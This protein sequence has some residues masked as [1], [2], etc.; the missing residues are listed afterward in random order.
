MSVELR[1][2]IDVDKGT[3]VGRLAVGW[4]V[5]AFAGDDRGDLAAF[6]ALARLVAEG[7]LADAVGIG[8][9]SPEAPTELPAVT[10]VTVAG[11]VG[12]VGLLSE[13]AA[14]A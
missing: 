4:R 14:R 1:P 12:L 5:A 7:A 2:A 6:A 9:L 13:L 3:V 10:D 8:V 11:P